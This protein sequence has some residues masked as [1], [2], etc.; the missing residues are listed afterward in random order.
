MAQL[1]VIHS[2][3]LIHRHVSLTPSLRHID[4]HFSP[5]QASIK[6]RK[7]GII[8]QKQEHS[9]SGRM[10][11]QPQGGRLRMSSTSP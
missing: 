10:A 7:A 3:R 11:L 5:R 8:Y 2:S 9:P 4:I 1:T 6:L